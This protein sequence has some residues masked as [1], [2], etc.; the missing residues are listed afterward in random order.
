MAL[1]FV[2]QK[3]GAGSRAQGVE[4]MNP[5]NPFL[6]QAYVDSR[7][8]TGWVAWL[9][10]LQDADTQEVGAACMAFLK[11][12]AVNCGLEIPSL[13]DLQRESLFWDGLYDF[14]KQESVTDLGLNTFA[15]G[16]VSIPPIGAEAGRRKRE[17]YVID[18]SEK[19]LLQNLAKNHRRNVRKAER[20]GLIIRATTEI[21][22]A[23]Q[24]ALLVGDSADRRRDRGEDTSGQ[25]E[26]ND[27][28]QLLNSGVACIYQAVDGRKAV[29]SVLLLMA[30]KGVYYHSA[31][32]SP[33]G[34][35]QGASPFLI[36]N[37][38][39]ELHSKGFEIF[40]LGPSS[41]AW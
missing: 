31:G 17:E 36:F 18:L 23:R 25:L 3:I 30:E 7:L 1:K 26:G 41:S 40:N 33:E 15:S 32:T 8:A 35:A 19:P 20:A 10:C 34:M 29:S 6:T 5:Q 24:H 27:F 21:D 14:C 16:A 22:A 11:K 38:A 2:A 9:L 4:A 37:I 28:S 12:G 39:G 13:P